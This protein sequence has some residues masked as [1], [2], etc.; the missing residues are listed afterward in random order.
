MFVS[1]TPGTPWTFLGRITLGSAAVTCGPVI[2][3]GSYKQLMIKYRI[4]GYSGGAVGRLLIGPTSPNNSGATNGTSM[5]EGVA[6]PTTLVSAA[7]VPLAVTVSAIGRSGTIWV[8]GES[9]SLKEIDVVGHNGT[10]S[11]ATAATLYRASSFFSDL[12]GNTLIQQAQ[13][14]V[15]LAISGSTISSTTTFNA[16]TSIAVW[17]KNDN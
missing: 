3:T 17:G 1:T 5:S 2:W 11:A 16:G 9:G 12:G 4:S 6:A 8:D 10:P 7:G 13:L 15:Y 14:S